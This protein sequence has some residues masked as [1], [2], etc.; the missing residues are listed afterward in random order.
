M[1]RSRLE[2]EN[3]GEPRALDDPPHD[4]R[5]IAN[6]DRVDI[7]GGP[8]QHRDT[9]T[10]HELE[11]GEVDHEMTGST[12]DDLIEGLAEPLGVRYVELSDELDDRFAR[13]VE[14]PLDLTSSAT[15]TLYVS[16]LTAKIAV[17]SSHPSGVSARSM[18]SRSSSRES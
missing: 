18:P 1:D 5:G 17:S 6:F 4:I 16:H 3:L 7:P 2:V 11:R 8:K 13:F 10:V 12:V 9:R 14:C 15:V